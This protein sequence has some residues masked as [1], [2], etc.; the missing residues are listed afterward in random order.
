MIVRAGTLKDWMKA[1]FDRGQLDDIAKYGCSAG[2]PR[3][4]YYRDTM[5]L[6]DKFSDDIWKL[7]E[8]SAESGDVMEFVASLN[9]TSQVS[10]RATFEN[11]MV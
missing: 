11:L 7:A 4:T 9:G 8:D 5:K 1:N 6:Y 2:F 10:S 3:L